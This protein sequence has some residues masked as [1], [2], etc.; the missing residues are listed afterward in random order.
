MSDEHTTGEVQ[1]TATP[2][3]PSVG[4]A[5][6]RNNFGIPIAI[7]MAAAL[8]SGA[9]YMS[10]NKAPSSV[11]V[12]GGIDTAQNTQDTPE[13]EVAPI[14]ETDHIRGNP[15]A[16]IIIVEYSDFDCP[17]C[18]IFH[19]TMTKIISEYGKDGKVAWVF[20]Q[21]PIKQLH[22]DAPKIAI[23]SECAAEL[24]GNDAFWKFSDA[25]NGSRKVTYGA[26]GN[27]TDVEPTDVSRLAE[28]AQT[29]GV[30]REKFNACLTSGK[31]DAKIE[32]DIAAA[33]KAGAQGTPYSIVMVG[34]QKGVINGAQPYDVV[35][36]IID[37][38]LTQLKSGAQ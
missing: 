26:N 15:N 32:A 16:D 29:A 23:A 17:F 20:R 35:K 2:R 13:M 11:N 9:I 21:F 24:G 10:G 14:S 33:T 30:E 31:Y 5:V 27:V 18:R 3:A 19:D 12:Q 22:P 28:F 36:G 1:Q 6:V 37:N 7:V 4:G 25:L 34:G 8:V 38:L